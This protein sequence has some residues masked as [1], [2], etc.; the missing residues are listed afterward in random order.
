M[1]TNFALKILTQKKVKMKWKTI[2]DEQIHNRG[3]E[4]VCKKPGPRCVCEK[5]IFIVQ[6]FIHR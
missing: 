4:H 2:K 1:Y 6:T 3:A 5:R